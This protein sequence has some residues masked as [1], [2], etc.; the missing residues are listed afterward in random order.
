MSDEFKACQ[1]KDELTMKHLLD[2]E[3]GPAT[4]PTELLH[5][6]IEAI[7]FML[8]WMPL[9]DQQFYIASIPQLKLKNKKKK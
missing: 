9:V 3:A 5:N 1:L 6:K 4:S 8:K 7:K 2:D